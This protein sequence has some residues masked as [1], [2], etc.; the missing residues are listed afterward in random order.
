MEEWRQKWAN[1]LKKTED[2]TE[3]SVDK[4]ASLA[5]TLTDKLKRLTLDEWE[6]K[7]WALEQEVKGYRDAKLD[8][9]TISRYAAAQMAEIENDRT[10]AGVKAFEDGLKERER[11]LKEAEDNWRDT[12]ADQL[13]WTRRFADG[14]SG[15]I[16]QMV[17]RGEVSLQNFASF[18]RSL[19]AGILQ[20]ILSKRIYEALERLIP[21]YGSWGGGSPGGGEEYVPEGGFTSASM[22]GPR[23]LGGSLTIAP[24]A[25]N[26]AYAAPVVHV[27]VKGDVTRWAE[28]SEAVVNTGIMHRRRIGR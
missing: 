28:F 20:D 27:H 12:H 14:F 5:A 25:V 3:K 18:F 8:E 16:G 11:L 1:I 22:G 26:L 6:Y 4:R 24:P 9:V 10:K 15:I 23:P 17:E 21:G 2:A 7:K 19:L 13:D